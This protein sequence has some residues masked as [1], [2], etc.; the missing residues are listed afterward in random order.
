MGDA[1]WRPDLSEAEALELLE[2][3]SHRSRSASWSRCPNSSLRWSTPTACVSWTARPNELRVAL[4]PRSKKPD[5]TLV[6]G[7]AKCL[8]H[9]TVDVRV[10][11]VAL[12]FCVRRW[13]DLEK[14]LT[15]GVLALCWEL[16]AG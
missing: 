2:C 4:V 16:T 11:A 9:E 6:C 13:D 12:F 10:P 8:S 1:H 14:R 3:A 5:L 7:R 15:R